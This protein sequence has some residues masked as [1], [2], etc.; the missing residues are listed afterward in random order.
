[1][2]LCW[3][4][5]LLLLLLQLLPCVLLLCACVAEALCQRLAGMQGQNGVLTLLDSWT[6]NMVSITQEMKPKLLLEA[7]L[8]RI[9]PA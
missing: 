4:L 6:K 2:L 9:T 3:V 1:V 5:Q 7:H 8:L